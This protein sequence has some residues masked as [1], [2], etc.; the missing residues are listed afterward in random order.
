MI[1]PGESGS[2]GKAISAAIM[3]GAAFR[4]GNAKLFNCAPARAQRTNTISTVVM[5]V[6]TFN[7]NW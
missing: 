6:G 4:N 3:I 1:A 5:I 7:R 2:Q